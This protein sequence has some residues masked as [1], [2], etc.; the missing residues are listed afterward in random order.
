MYFVDADH[1]DRCQPIRKRAGNELM[2]NDD[3][4]HD[5]S[6]YQFSMQR[7]IVESICHSLA[8]CLAA[9]CQETRMQEVLLRV[10]FVGGKPSFQV[11]RV[12]CLELP[13][14]NALGIDEWKLSGIRDFHFGR[15]LNDECLV[16]PNVM[17]V[18]KSAT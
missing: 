15:P 2:I 5:S 18:A 4:V 10:V 16:R 8:N 13:L 14:D 12:V 11:L 17:D 3:A 1:F 6:R 7:T 9:R